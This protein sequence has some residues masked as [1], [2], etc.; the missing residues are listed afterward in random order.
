MSKR[1][2]FTLPVVA[3]MLTSLTQPAHAVV[4]HIGKEVGV[5]M[6]PDTRDCVFFQLVGVSQPDPVAPG[7]PWIAV[8]RT[9]QGFK[10]IYALLLLAKGSG[11]QLTIETNSTAQSNCA[12]AVGVWQIYTSS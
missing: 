4:H 2:L 9:Q 3:L 11:M 12:G 5:I 10:E 6:P 1:S 7:I 8:P